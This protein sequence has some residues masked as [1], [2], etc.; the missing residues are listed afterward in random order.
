MNRFI[1]MSAR[2]AATHCHTLQHTT[3]HCDT[4]RHTTT[5]CNALQHTATH[6][7]TLQHTI[8]GRPSIW[9]NRVIHINTLS[10]TN[11]LDYAYPRDMLHILIRNAERRNES[12]RTCGLVH[13]T[14]HTGTRWNALPRTA[15]HCNALQRI[16]THCNALQ[17]TA[18]HCNMQMQVS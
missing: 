8:S 18:T 17:R 10:H 12:F 6:C 11:E 5:H 2:H 14:R 4:L 3:T 1:H 7:H 13:V 15:T 16:A 9:K